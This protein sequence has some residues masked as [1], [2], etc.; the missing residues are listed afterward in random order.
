MTAFWNNTNNWIKSAHNTKWCLIGCAIGDFGT[1]AFFQF[2]NYQLPTMTI[3]VLA[4]VNGL[5]TSILLETVILIRSGFNLSDALKTALG[6]SFIS[7][8]AMEAAMNTTDYLLTGGALLTWWVIPIALLVGFLT[9]WPYNYWRLQK[10][11]KACH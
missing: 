8:L 5:L 7:M 11:G 4:M 6:M 10:H 1:I 9:P 3:M 2:S